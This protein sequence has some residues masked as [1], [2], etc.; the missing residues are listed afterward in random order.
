MNADGQT[1]V[2]DKY[3][4]HSPP[5]GLGVAK[6]VSLVVIGTLIIFPLVS[7]GYRQGGD[8][9]VNQILAHLKS[10]NSKELSKYFATTVEMDISPNTVVCSKARAEHILSDFFFKHRVSTLKIIHQIDSKSEYKLVVILMNTNNGSFRTTL[11]MKNSG[12]GFLITEIRIE[13]GQDTSP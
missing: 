6:I 3:L 10:S 2:I 5:K 12:N 9:L 7:K 11:S 4:Y 1:I 8:D 13:N